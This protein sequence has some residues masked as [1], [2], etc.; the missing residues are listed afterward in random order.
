MSDEI[1]K[2]YE[3]LGLQPGASLNE[4]KEAYRDLVK[5][6][7][8]DRFAHDPKLQAKAQEKLKEI[9]YAF[10]RIQE[11]LNNLHTYQQA[12][13]TE[14][15]KFT[16]AEEST[17]QNTEQ[18]EEARESTNN[19][20]THDTPPPP[21][22]ETRP[23]VRF[24]ARTLDFWIFSLFIGFLLNLLFFLFG[25]LLPGEII[26]SI[27][28][29]GPYELALILGFFV[30]PLGLL[31]E[32][33]T[34]GFFGNTPGKEILKIRIMNEAGNELS[35]KDAFKRCFYIYV[36]GYCLG[37]PLI[38]IITYSWQYNRLGKYG[39]TSWDEKFNN[40]V[41]HSHIGR[42]RIA[43]W[44]VLFLLCT[45]VIGINKA[46]L[47]IENNLYSN[48]ENI[49]TA[50]EIEQK[51]SPPIIDTHEVPSSIKEPF[52]KKSLEK[53]EPKDLFQTFGVAPP[54]QPTDTVVVERICQ[55]LTNEGIT[56]IPGHKAV[57]L[58]V[59]N[60]LSATKISKVNL[61]FTNSNAKGASSSRNLLI[62]VP[63][64]SASLVRHQENGRQI[65]SS[66]VTL[67]F[68]PEDVEKI[69][70]L[71]TQVIQRKQ[72]KLEIVLCKFDCFRE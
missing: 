43:L 68:V 18:Y 17:R 53:A 19:T 15:E 23:W 48:N 69:D 14:E 37:I 47:R 10:Q 65:F 21:R 9:N 11:F 59:N 24:W 32:T 51:P 22:E 46:I 66:T 20:S 36:E 70:S 40:T 60:I 6:W 13:G 33:L 63:V 44:I 62:N 35:F 16:K 30:I 64:L 42:A 55:E 5:V 27:L 38:P 7:H 4:V 71:V 57:T 58:C 56:P 28:K 31:L 50:P 67:D 12:A 45:F 2:Y 72:G 41:T 26:A 49:L 61:R 52:E 29:R 25:F 8:H 1:L 34:M 3:D 39:K 54:K